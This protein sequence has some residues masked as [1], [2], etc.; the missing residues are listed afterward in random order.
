LLLY[1]TRKDQIT[2]SCGLCVSEHTILVIVLL[3][4]IF[5]CSSFCPVKKPWFLLQIRFH[6]QHAQATEEQQFS[7]N[8][9]RCFCLEDPSLVCAQSRIQSRK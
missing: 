4:V 8:E 5:F 3:K 1:S 9:V 7:P 6:M 2:G